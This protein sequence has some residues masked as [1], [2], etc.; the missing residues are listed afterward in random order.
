MTKKEI[1]I[2]ILKNIECYINT[3]IRY[4]GYEVIVGSYSDENMIMLIE[5][6]TYRLPYENFIVVDPPK[7]K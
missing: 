3:D 1:M 6:I 7:W 4:E 5:F 2:S